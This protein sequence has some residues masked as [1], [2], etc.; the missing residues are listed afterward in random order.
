VA[1]YNCS[2][3]KVDEE[4]IKRGLIGQGRHVAEEKAKVTL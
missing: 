3:S 2:G 1:V 4:E